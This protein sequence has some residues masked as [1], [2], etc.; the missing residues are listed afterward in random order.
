[1]KSFLLPHSFVV[2]LGGVV[3]SVA[4]ERLE[5]S[6]VRPSVPASSPRRSV[7]GMHGNLI[8]NP[9]RPDRKWKQG[10][11]LFRTSSC[12]ACVSQ[13]SW[14]RLDVMY[15]CTGLEMS[16]VD[17]EQEINHFSQICFSKSF[18]VETNVHGQ[19][20]LSKLTFL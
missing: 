6:V 1:M 9:A 14:R 11:C 18:Y 5:S 12:K 20:F 4:R 3:S 8:A 2:S 16:R 17:S 19:K 13:E 7:D 10:G 15:T